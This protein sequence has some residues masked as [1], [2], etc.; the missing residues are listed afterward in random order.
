M[1]KLS[2]S[3]ITTALLVPG[4]LFAQGTTTPLV[5]P[6][7]TPQSPFYFLD[8]LSESIQEFFTFNQSDKAR[9]NLK[10][11]NER[12]AEINVMLKA[13]STD[14]A[15]IKVAE[16]GLKNNLDKA[17][18]IVSKEKESGQDVGELAQEVKDE[19]NNQ[20]SMMDEMF[21]DENKADNNKGGENNASS[22]EKN[23][24]DRSSIK[25]IHDSLNQEFDNQGQEMEGMMNDSQSGDNKSQDNQSDGE[26]QNQ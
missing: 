4:L 7:I 16:E 1:K 24:N 18:E 15:D 5:N 25:K 10:F 8:K 6:G 3:M 12:L 11:A 17:S 9:L 23:R 19:M 26:V 22:T 13:S 2:V 21:N 14:P 20:K